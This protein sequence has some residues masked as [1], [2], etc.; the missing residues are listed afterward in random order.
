MIVIHALRGRDGSITFMFL[1]SYFC[2]RPGLHAGTAIPDFS[3][4][5]RTVL[6]VPPRAVHSFPLRISFG[7]MTD[8]ASVAPDV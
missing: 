3:F 1:I 8:P 6:P 2:N 4:W 5:L 7:T